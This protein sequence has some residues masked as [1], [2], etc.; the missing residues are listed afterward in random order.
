M[1]TSKLSS[2]EFS[3]DTGRAKRAARKGP[4]IITE[5]GQPSHV[6][7]TFDDYAQ[8]VGPKGSIIDALG[9]PAGIENVSLDIP[10]RRDTARS[11]DLR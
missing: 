2:R 6:L 7:L 4:V 9:E 8:L 3:R 11:A 1:P 10:K 5:R